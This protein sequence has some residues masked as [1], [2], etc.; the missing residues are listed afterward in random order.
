MTRLATMG[1]LVRDGPEKTRL[2]V[3]ATAPGKLA[4][5]AEG[6]KRPAFLHAADELGQV[7]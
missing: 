6:A 5:R 2:L 3:W 4:I 1:K 7:R